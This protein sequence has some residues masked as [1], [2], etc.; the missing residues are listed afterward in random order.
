MLCYFGEQIGDATERQCIDE[1]IG[2][3]MAE[4]E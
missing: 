2:V 1:I 4:E 3:D